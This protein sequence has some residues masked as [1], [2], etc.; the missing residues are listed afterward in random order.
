T[1]LYTAKQYT[2]SLHDPLPSS[3]YATRALKNSKEWYETGPATDYLLD[4]ESVLTFSSSI[5]SPWPEN[6]IV[7]A[8][9]FPGKEKRAAVLVLANWNA[10]WNGPRGLCEWL[11]ELGICGVKLSL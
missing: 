10:K 2:L 1:Y 7:H 5:E 9:L 6:N 3:E 8:Q 4:A 11:P